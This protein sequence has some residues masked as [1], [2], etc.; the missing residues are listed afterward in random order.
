M[1]TA[2]TKTKMITMGLISIFIMGTTPAVFANNGHQDPV[3]LKA[4]SDLNK[5]PLF[6]LKLNTAES[7]EFVVRV[8]D[9]NGDVLYSEVLKGK[10]VNRQYKFDINEEAVFEAFHVRFEITSVKSHETFI[11]NVTSSNREVREIIVAKL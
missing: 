11:Y 10:N 6:Q 1:K 7:G 4:I 5:Q 8:K 2:I 3:E 9:G